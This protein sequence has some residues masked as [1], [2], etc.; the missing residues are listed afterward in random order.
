MYILFEVLLT[1]MVRLKGNQV[2]FY[3]SCCLVFSSKTIMSS[4]FENEYFEGICVG[5]SVLAQ[6]MNQKLHW[7][8]YP[9]L[10]HLSPKH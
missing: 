1:N 4:S 7:L 2:V 3:F 6:D 10:N 8:K 5:Y 9:R